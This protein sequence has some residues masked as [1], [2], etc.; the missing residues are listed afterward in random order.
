MKFRSLLLFTFL[1]LTAFVSGYQLHA[2]INTTQEQKGS[3]TG[4][5]GI[6]FKST[7]PE[8]LRR[9]YEKNLDFKVNPYGAVF[10]WRKSINSA[11][12]GFTQWSPFSQKTTYFLP[13]T[14]DFMVNYR[15]QNLSNLLTR[16]KDNQVTILDSVAAYDY[17][18][19][20]HILDGDGNKIELWEPNDQVYEKMGIDMGFGTMK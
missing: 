7:D 12:K 8:S 9:W 5:G 20:V 19:F 13:S 2:H 4:I 3:V 6:F 11:E 1:I 18:K 14:K 17:G 10:E 15:V 16:L